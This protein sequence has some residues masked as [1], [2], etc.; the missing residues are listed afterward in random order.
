M[1]PSCPWQLHSDWKQPHF[2]SKF[3]VLAIMAST[4]AAAF[5]INVWRR[6]AGKASRR[7]K[8]P[9]GI[10]C[11]ISLSCVMYLTLRYLIYFCSYLICFL[12][13]VRLTILIDLTFFL[14]GF[15]TVLLTVRVF[16]TTLV[17]GCFTVVLVV[18]ILAT[19]CF[20]FRIM[21]FFSLT[22][23]NSYLTWSSVFFTF[24]SSNRFTVRLT[25]LSTCY[26]LMTFCISHLVLVIF[27]FFS[28]AC[29]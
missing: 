18:I 16:L 7:T 28:S 1:Q 17:V 9:K 13:M 3:F 15:M 10:L 5:S 26:F 24:L 25:G 22:V 11:L 6:S 12:I 2:D 29:T 14:M 21:I 20:S 8:V 19:C 27:L 23:F 4:Y